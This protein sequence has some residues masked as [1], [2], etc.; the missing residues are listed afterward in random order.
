VK[1]MRVFE[2]TEIDGIL[3]EVKVEACWDKE[4]IGLVLMP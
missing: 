3:I 4:H 2:Q 1:Q